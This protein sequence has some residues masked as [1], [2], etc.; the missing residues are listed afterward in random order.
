MTFAATA[1]VQAWVD[2]TTNDGWRLND[3]NED[4]GGSKVD[5]NTREHG[6]ASERPNLDVTYT[7]P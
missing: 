6:T 7:P 4:S 1:D 5:Y 3:Q 2:G